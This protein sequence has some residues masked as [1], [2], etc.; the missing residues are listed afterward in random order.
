MSRE[1][2]EGFVRV[3]QGLRAAPDLVEFE[4]LALAA[5]PSLEMLRQAWVNALEAQRLGVWQAIRAVGEAVACTKSPKERRKLFNVLASDGHCTTA[6]VSQHF[7]L[8]VAYGNR[9]EHIV[10]VSF[11]LLRACAQA[12]TR[13]GQDALA[14]LEYALER[15]WHASDVAK[16]GRKDEAS[17]S[18]AK[19]CGDCGFKTAVKGKGA[20]TFAGLSVYCPMCIALAVRENRPTLQLEL[21]PLGVLE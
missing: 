10:D 2:V 18:L 16:L 9:A 11:A 4:R 5:E 13:T 15:D 12:A 8:F 7:R 20:K 14:V 19:E 6:F 21:A 17:V 3:V 1:S